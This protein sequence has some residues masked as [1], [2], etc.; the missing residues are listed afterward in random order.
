MHAYTAK[1][2]HLY[3]TNIFHHYILPSFHQV[4][5]EFNICSLDTFYSMFIYFISVE[6]H[7]KRQTSSYQRKANWIHCWWSCIE[8]MYLHFFSKSRQLDGV[9]AKLLPIGDKMVSG[10]HRG[11]DT[12]KEWCCRFIIFFRPLLFMLPPGDPH[13][14]QR[15]Q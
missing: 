9:G 14:V 15:E 1:Y 8:I 5:Y 3:G 11:K 12:E 7:N 10:I 6:E 4:I 2:V 13:N